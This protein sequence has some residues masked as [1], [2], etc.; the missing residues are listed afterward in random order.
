MSLL[1]VPSQ[2][3]PDTST[4]Q[5]VKLVVLSLVPLTKDA[6][7]VYIGCGCLLGAA[8]LL[9]WP[10]SSFRV[11]VPGLLV[12]LAMEVVDLRDGLR[13]DNLNLG[14]SL[15]DLVNTNL[16]PLIVVWLARRRRLRL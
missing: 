16:I 4:Y 6:V 15:H 1:F 7:H 11:L 12:S 2:F 13:E 5:R 8:A 14:A 10:L 3:S 9:R